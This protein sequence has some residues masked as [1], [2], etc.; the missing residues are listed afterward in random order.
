[1]NL[2]DQL[3]PVRESFISPKTV[4]FVITS[5]SDSLGEV[6]SY[7]VAESFSGIDVIGIGKEI[8]LICAP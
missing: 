4:S 6:S 3:A 5:N 7:V 1:M 8:L 2:A